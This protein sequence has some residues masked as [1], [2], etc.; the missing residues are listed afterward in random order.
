MFFLFRF[1][2]NLNEIKAKLIL[3]LNKGKEIKNDS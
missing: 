2:N 3:G 1:L